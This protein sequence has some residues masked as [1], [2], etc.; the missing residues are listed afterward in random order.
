MDFKSLAIETLVDPASAARRMLIRQFG[1]DVVW[2]GF[3]LCVVL[4][5]LLYAVQGYLLGVP[6]NGVFPMLSAP[7]FGVLLVSLQLA[8]TFCALVVGRWL[9]GQARFVPYLGLLVWLRFL[10]IAVQAVAI[11][12]I[13]VV[14]PLAIVLNF[15]SAIYG[16][17][18]LLHFTNEGFGLASLA[19]S[20]GVVLMAGLGAITTVLLLMGLFV[21]AILETS[22]V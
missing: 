19:K 17:Y 15:I 22:N 16:F 8:F 14:P 5:V 11:A 7:A 12:L 2:T 18:L 13:F 6:S 1:T 3:A 21:P 4:T 10:N 20:L 9:G